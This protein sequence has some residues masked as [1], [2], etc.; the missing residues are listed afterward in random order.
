MADKKAEKAKKEPKARGAGIAGLVVKV[1]SVLSIISVLVLFSVIFDLGRIGLREKLLGT[2]MVFIGLYLVGSLATL[3]LAPKPAASASFDSAVIHSLQEFQSKAT[4]RFALMQSMIDSVS[5]NDHA[6]LL[7][8]NKTLKAQLDAIHQ[9]ERVKVDSEVEILRQRNEELEQ[10][11][12][13]WALM[14][15]SKSVAGEPVASMK[16][17]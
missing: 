13:Q 6:S 7:E 15:V 17:A 1:C 5:G 4:S 9:A 2:E 11:I 8:Q 3:V 12:R 16:A 14:A 10:Q